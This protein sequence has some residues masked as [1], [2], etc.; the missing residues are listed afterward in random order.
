MLHTQD[1]AFNLIGNKGCKYI[2][3]INTGRLISLR[4]GTMNSY[5]GSAAVED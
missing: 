5:T 4:V 3:N 2:T 1:A